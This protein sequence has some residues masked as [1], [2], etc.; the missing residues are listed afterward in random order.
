ME[1]SVKEAMVLLTTYGLKVIGAIIILIVGRIIAGWAEKAIDRW[2]R[3]SENI[4]ETLR[5][6][7]AKVGRYLVL[8]FTFLAV[9]SQFGIET[10][11]IVA[12][13]GVAGLAIGLAL[14]G[15]LSNVAAGVMILV[16]RPF[17]VGDF[18]EAAGIAGTVKSISVFITELAT[19]DNVQ[20]LAHQ[21]PSM[22]VPP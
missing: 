21:W 13:L 2:L 4:D 22:G 6:F 12:I 11:S 19:P 10:T 20:I 8:I 14:Q 9:L 15:T 16:F 3:K 7:F 17:K 1:E 5:G 18:V